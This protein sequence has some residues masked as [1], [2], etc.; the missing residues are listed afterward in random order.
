VFDTSV[1]HSTENQSDR[2]RYVLLIRMWH[3]E[4]TAVEVDAFK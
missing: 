3:P 4:L 1:I 2:V